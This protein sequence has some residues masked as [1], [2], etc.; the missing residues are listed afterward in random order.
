MASRKY[1]IVLL[2]AT[3]YTGALTAKHIA[4]HFPHDLRWVIA[5][6]SKD[7]LHELA[8]E[9]RGLRKEGSQPG[10]LRCLLHGPRGS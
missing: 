5:G 9:I 6:R 8:A 4:S 7:K 2:G 10:M 3:G 1:D